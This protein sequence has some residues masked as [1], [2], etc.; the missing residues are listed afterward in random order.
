MNSQ[1]KFTERKIHLSQELFL[2]LGYEFWLLADHPRA[3]LQRNMRFLLF[4]TVFPHF[5]LALQGIRAAS[6]RPSS[7]YI[8]VLFNKKGEPRQHNFPLLAW[9]DRMTNR[10]SN[11]QL[12]AIRS[13][14]AIIESFQHT[15][16]EFLLVL[17]CVRVRRCIPKSLRYRPFVSHHYTRNPTRVF[18]VTVFRNKWAYGDC[19]KA[20]DVATVNSWHCVIRGNCERFS[21]FGNF[22]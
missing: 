22:K 13:S 3:R 10:K 18:A 5:L 21:A 12:F 1:R 14:F 15:S 4:S 16:T 8:M 6:I 20:V 9:S 7:M 11:D 17:F 19:S 2:A